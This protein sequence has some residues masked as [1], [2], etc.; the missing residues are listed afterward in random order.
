MEF[1]RQE[2]WNKLPF[3]LPG[4]LPDPGIKPTFPALASGFFTTTPPEKPLEQTEAFPKEFYKITERKTNQAELRE[5]QCLQAQECTG[6]HVQF[7]MAWH[8]CLGLS[9]IWGAQP[10]QKEIGSL[11]KT[12]PSPHWLDKERHPRRRKKPVSPS[13]SHRPR[14]WSLWPFLTLVPLLECPSSFCLSG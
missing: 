11:V 3:P 6:P 7:Q 14:P 1:S 13:P 12:K 4:D 9:P 5:P 10:G 2:Y 8:K